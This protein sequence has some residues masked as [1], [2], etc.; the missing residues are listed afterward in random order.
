MSTLARGGEAREKK[1]S[2]GARASSTRKRVM[3]F[4]CREACK[5]EEKR[6]KLFRDGSFALT[7]VYPKIFIFRGSGDESCNEYCYTDLNIYCS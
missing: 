7:R 6:R 1:G 5:V 4:L 3:G 2:S